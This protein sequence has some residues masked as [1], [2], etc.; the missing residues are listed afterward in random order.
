MQEKLRQL[1]AIPFENVTIHAPTKPTKTGMI[2]FETNKYSVPE[3]CIGKSLT[4]YSSCTEIKIYYKGKCVAKHPRC[5]ER[6]KSFINPLHRNFQKTSHKAK[7]DRVYNL[8]KNMDTEFESFLLK[9]EACGEN[10][11]NTAYEIFTRLRIYSRAILRS[12]ARE[13]IKIQSPRLKTF[14][15]YL[16]KEKSVKDEIVNPQNSELMEI[17]YTPRS[18]EIYGK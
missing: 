17:S 13:T 8:I 3:S 15:S 18:L 11:K 6:E 5:F 1:P 12:I 4:V 10:P 2:I 9:N 16:E 7:L 14:L